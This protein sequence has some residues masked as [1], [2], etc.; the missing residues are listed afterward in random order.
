MFR[1][2]VINNTV[3][4]YIFIDVR[5]TVYLRIITTWLLI[6]VKIMD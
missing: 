3:L 2:Y 4:A 6:I 1:I 5:L